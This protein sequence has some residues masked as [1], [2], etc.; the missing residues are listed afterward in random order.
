MDK[1]QYLTFQLAGGEYGVPLLRVR[2]IIEY[3]EPTAVPHAPPVV[4]GLVNL[5][6]AVLPVADLAVKLGLGARP[7]TRKTCVVVVELG[8]SERETMGIVADAVS[9]VVELEDGEIQPAPDFGLPV[10][11]EYLRGLGRSAKGFIL[12]LEAGKLFTAEELVAVSPVPIAPP[13]AA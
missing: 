9:Q 1:N 13:E 11:P 6:G 7:V 8:G 3:Q 5:R 2:E 10:K 12:L 4:R